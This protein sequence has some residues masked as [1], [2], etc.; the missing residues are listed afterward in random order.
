M[1]NSRM[2]CLLAVVVAF[3]GVKG[4][5]GGDAGPLAAQVRD[6]VESG[7]ARRGVAARFE[8]LRT[9]TAERLDASRGSQEFRD[10][11]GNC[12]LSW[13][14]HLLSD[15]LAVAVEGEVFTRELH[16][17]ASRRS[18]GL[19]E[20][21]IAAAAKLDMEL[22]AR[23]ADAQG[24]AV[25]Q[26]NAALMEAKSAWLAGL[27]PLSVE[28][29]ELLAERLYPV[30]TDFDPPL[31]HRFASVKEGREV[32]DLLEKADRAQWLAAAQVL[33]RLTDRELLEELTRAGGET[34]AI[35][36]RIEGAI[37][38]TFDAAGGKVVIGGPGPNIYDL[39]A[40]TDV[41]IVIDPG[42][43][44]IYKEGSVTLWRPLL[45]VVDLTGNDRYEGTKPGIQGSAMLGISVLV[46]F[47][48]DDTYIGRDVCQGSSVGGVGILVDEDGS[49][50]YLGL[51][52]CQGQAIGGV[53][54]LLDARGSDRY[55]A[56]L[57]AQGV[58]GP[59]G[60]GLLDDGAGDDHYFAGGLYPGGYD[61]SPGF[62]G[63]SQGV[64]LGPR[65]S[66]NGGIGVLL[67]GGGDDV[68][69]SD[70]FGHGGGYWFAAGFARDFGGN[71]KRM[72][73]TLTNYDGTERTEKRFLRW[74]VGYGCHYATGFLCDD[75]GD[76]EY[77][78]DLGCVAYQ[79]D[80]GSAFII[81]A[82][83]NDLYA[84]NPGAAQAHNAGLAVLFDGGGDDRY[85]G[86][87][88][89]NAHATVDYHPEESGGN[90]AML[91][92]IG[93]ADTYV[94]TNGF[95]NGELVRGWE[96]G[97]LIDRP[98]RASSEEHAAEDKAPATATTNG[99]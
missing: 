80:I 55:R 57:T 81:D 92:D 70:Y 12:R 24:D 87:Q 93:G 48:G 98:R 33:V 52:R 89:G 97:F 60:L 63:W 9:Y 43:D 25:A 62:G 41:L 54:I 67:D 72:G 69:E 26:V 37:T 51:R 77:H 75:G 35:D 90:F 34:A 64:G 8:M 53:G 96:G 61:D 7:L 68:Y 16:T 36:P 49:D 58:G 40:L 22:A 86:P 91:L 32:C 94:S 23:D 30:T 15:L 18:A 13:V 3:L 10:K 38:R 6:E 66:A 85:L 74:G 44:D 47:E 59:L 88:P 76:D 29:R 65:G 83:G 31:G 19:D 14:E 39:D 42:G 4:S 5:F 11:T 21:L 50:S 1:K 99:S 20:L 71:D 17:I 56:A 27:V 45:M 84:G 73:A 95:S 2:T 46:D 79:W 28:E 78:G 82:D